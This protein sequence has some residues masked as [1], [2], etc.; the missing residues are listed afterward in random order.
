MMVFLKEMIRELRQERNMSQ[1]Q[2]GK[3]AGMGQQQISRYE[4]GDNIPSMASVNKI[5]SALGVPG[6]VFFSD[7]ITKE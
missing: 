1:A 6:S 4:S 3:L 5:A 7:K 2:L